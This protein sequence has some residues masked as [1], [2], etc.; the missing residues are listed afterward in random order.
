MT[1]Q[2]KKS[3]LPQKICPVCGFPFS[4]RKKWEKNWTE[5]KY[6]SERCRKGAGKKQQPE[7]P[8]K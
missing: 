7:T 5:V 1:K 3:H 4:W 8:D 2:Q 6:C